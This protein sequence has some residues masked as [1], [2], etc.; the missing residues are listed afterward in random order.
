M[1]KIYKVIWSKTK[2]R[3]VVV[4]ELAH[5]CAKRTG[6]TLGKSAAALMAVL[7]LTAGIGFLPVQAENVDKG[8]DNYI[9]GDKNV[10]HGNSNN[11]FGD[12][13]AVEGNSN[14]IH[15][16]NSI[17]EG[18]DNWMNPTLLKVITTKSVRLI[19]VKLLVIM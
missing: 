12:D 6:W 16:D 5:S 15:G 9:S 19:T 10:I 3:Y 17:I 1:N 2:Q 14:T 7:A 8:Q 4:S 13:N 18:N 11:V